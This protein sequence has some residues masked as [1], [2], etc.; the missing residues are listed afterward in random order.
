MNERFVIDTTS[1]ISYF[2]EVFERGSQISEKA[3]RLIEKG[4]SGDGVILII[5]SIV[6]I[7]IYKK[8]FVNE[9][10]AN[11]IRYEVYERIKHCPS[12]EIKPIEAE[13]L[14]NFIKITGIEVGHNFDNHDKQILASA[15]MLQCPLITSDGPITRYA[16]K[17]RKGIIP[18][19]IN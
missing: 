18:H 19:V 12:I 7:E 2:S 9:E 13:V 10:M 14:E 1:L 5:P 16:T 6:F 15:M 17:T 4:F 3:L 8:W 11:K